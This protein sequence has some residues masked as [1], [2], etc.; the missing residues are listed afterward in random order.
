M[1]GNVERTVIELVDGYTCEIDGQNNYML[2]KHG[3]SSK[4][5]DTRRVVGY[6]SGLEQALRRL[7]D[8]LAIDGIRGRVAPLN[9]AVEAIRE[10]KRQISKLI[11]EILETRA[12][13]EGRTDRR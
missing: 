13:Y 5:K 12:K 3:V 2:I 1:K 6:Y 9:E 4:G 7:A 8:E 11:M 10:S